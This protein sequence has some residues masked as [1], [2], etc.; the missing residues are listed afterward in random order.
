[1]FVL[2]IVISLAAIFATLL[3]T[4]ALGR[5][6]E[7]YTPYQGQVSCDP[8]AKPGTVSL[9]KLLQGKFGGG[10]SGI[11]RHCSVG[12][13][14]EH[15][16]G[17]AFDWRLNANN[18]ADRARA[19]RA[20]KWLTTPVGE[21]RILRAHRLG[22]MYMIW[23]RKMWRG[24]AVEQGWQEYT[25]ESPHRDHMHISLS[26]SGARKLTSWWTDQPKFD[27]GP[28]VKWIGEM[29]PRAKGPR[30]DPC[31]PSLLR[32]VADKLGRYEAQEGETVARVARFFDKPQ[33]RI[34]RWN[35]WDQEGFVWINPGEK[36]WV[37]KPPTTV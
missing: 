9:S 33:E 20:I 32:P 1:M 19:N 28:C 29:A 16:E 8:A 18:K 13:T 11:S 3:P 26:W 36:I 35:G 2:K 24:Y 17:R 6:V 23:N 4:S 15:K 12:G 5:T 31:P 7:T 30:F 22:I 14:S 25:G 37:K 21:E 27:Y 34:R 10:S